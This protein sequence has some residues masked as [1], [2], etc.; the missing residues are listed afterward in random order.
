MPSSPQCWTLC[1]MEPTARAR[2]AGD[3]KPTKWKSIPPIAVR[4]AVAAHSLIRPWLALD[5]PLQECRWRA[6]LMS[7]QRLRP[8]LCY[9]CAGRHLLGGPP[10][11][12]ARLRLSR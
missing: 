8:R 4:G 11:F 10:C 6:W 7:Q 5:L 3:D 9:S 1:V 2:L 12:N